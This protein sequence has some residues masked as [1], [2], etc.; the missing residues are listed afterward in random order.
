MQGGRD[1]NN[2]DLAAI[3]SHL[4][5]FASEEE[6]LV[7]QGG[8]SLAGFA[9]E[10]VTDNVV[11]RLTLRVCKL[12]VASS[13]LFARRICG[14][15]MDLPIERRAT[16]A[17]SILTEEPMTEEANRSRGAGQLL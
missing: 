11:A 9:C 14:P 10:L 15:A 12:F 5:L 7:A 13:P 1:L 6:G 16:K 8:T 17:Q 4:H 2:P 3:D